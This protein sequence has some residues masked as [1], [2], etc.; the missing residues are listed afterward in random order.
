[1]GDTN[2]QKSDREGILAS[3]LRGMG[4]SG[5][6]R[7][8]P[9]Q[10][11]TQ[12]DDGLEQG[13]GAG[14]MS[15]LYHGPVQVGSA[16]EGVG[17]SGGNRVIKGSGSQSHLAVG[18]GP[19]SSRYRTAPL[20]R[21]ASGGLAGKDAPEEAI[22]Q[23]GIDR[24]IVPQSLQEDKNTAVLS[25]TDSGSG[26]EH[27]VG[28]A[29]GQQLNTCEEDVEEAQCP[30]NEYAPFAVTSDQPPMVPQRS[31]GMAQSYRH[32][33]FASGQA[34]SRSAGSA[35][36]SQRPAPDVESRLLQGTGSVRVSAGAGPSRVGP[37]WGVV[38][39]LP[40]AGRPR[41]HSTEEGEGLER[42][43]GRLRQGGPVPFSVSFAHSSIA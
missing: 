35:V 13:V 7:R 29:V 14:C 33:R 21:S 11:H 30:E 9:K 6:R 32:A 16:S 34:V 25:Q 27:T 23:A 42:G 5:L 1:M 26:K 24:G 43:R 41:V 40:G 28:H 20:Q 10:V 2:V 12:D 36:L 3:T 37:P 15:H 17:A 22:A 18:G 8:R 31:K 4:W 19:K 39:G 38:E